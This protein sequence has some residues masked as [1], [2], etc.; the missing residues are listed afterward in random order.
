[1][2]KCLGSKVMSKEWN[3]Y[4]RRA[5]VTRHYLLMGKQ[6]NTVP[7]NIQPFLPNRKILP[8]SGHLNWIQCSRS[9][10]KPGILLN[11]KIKLFIF[12]HW[13]HYFIFVSITNLEICFDFQI[14]TFGHVV[15]WQCSWNVSVLPEGGPMRAEICRSATVWIKCY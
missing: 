8:H 4:F 1:V 10:R 3:S 7:L 5:P 11:V 15:C 12:M 6:D 13:C 14:F 9:T 2:G